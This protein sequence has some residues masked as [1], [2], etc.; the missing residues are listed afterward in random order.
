[1]TDASVLPKLGVKQK[2]CPKCGQ[3]SECGAGYDGKPCWCAALPP[4]VPIKDGTDCQCPACLAIE[5]RRL[6]SQ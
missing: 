2:T 5:V 1:M 6:R 4:I 3:L